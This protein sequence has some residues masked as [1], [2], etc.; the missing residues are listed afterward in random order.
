MQMVEKTIAYIFT[1]VHAY[2]FITR[3]DKSQV[4]DN[5]FYLLNSI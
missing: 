1:Y 2:T 4:N 3:G 5:S